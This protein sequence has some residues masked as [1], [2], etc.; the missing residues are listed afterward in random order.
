MK[1]VFQMKTKSLVNA[2]IMLAIYM[3]FFVLYNIGV[4]P[5]IMS[6][7]L[8]VPLIVYSVTTDRV[9]DV[10]WLL[11]GCFIGTFLFGSVY[12]LVTTLNY[13]LMGA[14]IGIGIIKKWPYWQRLLNAA[15]VSVISFPIITYVV[16][17]LN[18]QESMAQMADEMNGMLEYMPAFLSANS[19]EMLVTVQNMVSTM[20]TTLLPTILILMGLAEAFLSDMVA[21]NVLRRMNY[22]VPRRGNIHSLQ[23]GA[24]LAV[25]L[26]ISQVAILFTSNHVLNVVLMNIVVLLNMLFLLQ[27][28]VVAMSYFRFRNQRGF[29]IFIII[30]ALMSSFS[31]FISVLGLMDALFNYRERFSVKKS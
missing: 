25:I 19:A 1:G 8:P 10:L 13:G 29:G 11:V 26:L 18:L 27:G 15:I 12:G 14:L 21:T 6:I 2:A 7:L 3:V 16:T 20:M 5:T 17:G 9:R 28:I 30:F 23:L 24:K 22:E 31:M 4:L